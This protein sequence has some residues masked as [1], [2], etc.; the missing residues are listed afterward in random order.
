[1]LLYS[2]QW[3]ISLHRDDWKKRLTSIIFLRKT[4]IYCG[5][6]RWL[7]KWAGN[8][9]GQ[10]LKVK[11]SNHTLPSIIPIFSWIQ[12]L[13][14]L[15]LKS[16]TTLWWNWTSERKNDLSPFFATFVLLAILPPYIKPHFSRTYIWS[17]MRK[18]SAFQGN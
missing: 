3:N 2:Q 10:I 9:I 14:W 12:V 6:L 13:N 4:A 18:K 11:K 5:R 8:K 15:A 16:N 1:M 7:W 17:I